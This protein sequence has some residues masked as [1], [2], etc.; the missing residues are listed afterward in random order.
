MSAADKIAEARA[1]I[2]PL[3]G[4]TPGP[5][6]S[7]HRGTR[8]DIEC[9]KDYHRVTTEL[10]AADPNAVAIVHVQWRLNPAANAALI[11]AA[12]AL[13]D[14]VAALADLA[15]AQAQEIARLRWVLGGVRRAI[16]TG[17]NDPLMIWR[18]QINIALG[19]A[20]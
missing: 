8:K 13:R 5:W 15:D 17:R 4:N 11:A 1:L 9:R 14:T 10:E 18:D 6:V 16:D 2:E 19:D 7:Q 20:T 12:P 3:T